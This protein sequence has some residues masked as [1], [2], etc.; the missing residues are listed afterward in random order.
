MIFVTEMSFECSL[1]DGIIE[2]G[3]ECILIVPT[4]LDLEL[5]IAIH[6]H[7]HIDCHEAQ[8]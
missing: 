8:S 1:C 7:R 4:T 2:E 3:D 6:E 5:G